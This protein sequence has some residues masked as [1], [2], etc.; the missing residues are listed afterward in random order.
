M[1]RGIK[2]L[3]AFSLGAAAGVAASWHFL[4]TKYEQITKEEVESFKEYWSNRNAEENNI[5]EDEPAPEEESELSKT[6]RMYDDILDEEDYIENKEEEGSKVLNK[7]VVISP[8]ELGEIEDY[9]IIDLV[10]YSD[11]VLTDDKCG[12]IKDIAN[13]VGA[14][15]ANHFGQYEPDAVHIRNDRLKCY[16]EI[17]ADEEQYS[18]LFGPANDE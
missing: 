10:Y 8:N 9:D 15:F 7:P 1:Y 14:D 11:G 2:Y 16:Y 4:K 3:F 18:N 17:L 5:T 12:P 6:L 13:T